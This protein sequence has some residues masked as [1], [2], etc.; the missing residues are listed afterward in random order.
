M[1]RTISDLQAFIHNSIVQERFHLGEAGVHRILDAGKAWD[2][3]ATLRAGGAAIFP[4]TYL[5][6][7][8]H[9]VASVVHGCLDSGADQ[10]LVIGVLHALSQEMWNARVREEQNHD[11]TKEIYWGIQGPNCGERADWKQ[12]FSLLNFQYL[13][14]K[15]VQRRGIKSPK[16][17]LRYPFLAGGRPDLFEGIEDIKAIAQDSVVV[18]TGDLFHHGIGYGESPLTALPSEAGG[19]ELAHKTIQ[20][21]LSHL[22]HDDYKEYLKHCIASKSDAKDVGQL[23]RYLLGPLKGN[24]LDLVTCDT[25]LMWDSLPPT[26]VAASLVELEPIS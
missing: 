13:M 9:Q 23:L 1:P 15:E 17:I 18:A 4:H 25:S 19:K 11:V 7:C 20:E 10:I 8:G 21:G 14:Q 3:S 6:K 2:V 24:I 16:L 26:W 12:E 5:E 22:A